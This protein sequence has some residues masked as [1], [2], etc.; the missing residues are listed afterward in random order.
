MIHKVTNDITVS[1]NLVLKAVSDNV[2]EESIL[3]EDSL[4]IDQFKNMG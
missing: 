4:V 3:I 2:T 1:A